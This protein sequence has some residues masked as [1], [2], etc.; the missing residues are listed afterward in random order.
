MGANKRKPLAQHKR[1]LAI[2]R[3]CTIECHV[4]RNSLPSSFSDYKGL[5]VANISKLISITGSPYHLTLD[6]ESQLG[7]IVLGQLI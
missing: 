2:C 1:I 7:T 4:W 5:T 3:V 6:T